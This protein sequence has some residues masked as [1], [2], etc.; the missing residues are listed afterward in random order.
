MCCFRWQQ[1][2]YEDTS[3]RCNHKSV[4]N[5]KHYG[6]ICTLKARKGFEKHEAYLFASLYDCPL[7]SL[8]SF[9][10]I[11]IVLMALESVD[12]ERRFS[13]IVIVIMAPASDDRPS[14]FSPWEGI[15]LDTHRGFCAV[16]QHKPHVHHR[17][18]G[19]YHC[20][21]C[22]RGG[23]APCVRGVHLHLMGSIV[24]SWGGMTPHVLSWE[25][26]TPHV[27]GECVYILYIHAR[28]IPV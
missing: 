28:K 16:V 11:V 12:S 22:L 10:C 24:L 14:V 1:W 27:C 3:R 18:G 19:M 15:A 2:Y 8:H 17:A 9:S 13:C 20:S 21:F 5:L 25:G 4:F 6:R 23:I 26:M 7:H